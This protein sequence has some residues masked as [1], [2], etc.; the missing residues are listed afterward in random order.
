MWSEFVLI[1]PATRTRG[2]ELGDDKRGRITRRLLAPGA[3]LLRRPVAKPARELGW[4][5]RIL[6]A[7]RAGSAA[8]KR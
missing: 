4:R 8:A 1:G 7:L 2:E 6:V 5:A 3:P